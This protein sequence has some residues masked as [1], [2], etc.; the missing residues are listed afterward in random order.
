M[1]HQMILE[2]ALAQ[3]AIDLNCTPED[4]TCPGNKVVLSAPHPH[5]RRY[6]KLPFHCNLVT[7]G[8]GAV[9]S[10][11]PGLEDTVLRY[12]DSCAPGH[13]FDMPDLNRLSDMMSPHGLRVR[14]MAEYFLPASD[15]PSTPSC[16]FETRL[17]QPDDFASLYRPEW[18][19][20]LCEKRK[21]L[22]SLAVGAY[23]HGRLVGLAGAS[24]DCGTMW[25]IG[26]DVLP[27]YRRQGIA[28][29][30]TAR[31][32]A[33]IF[34]R[35]KVPFYCAAWCN[36]PSVRNAIRAGFRPAWSELTLFPDG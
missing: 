6:L 27:E 9:A 36:L 23:D 3:S 32:S 33:E 10:V 19:N 18:S 25:Q 2:T 14:Y 16:P 28:S 12:M 8:T 17:M 11:R 7:Y 4:L 21:E 30:L 34:L 1:T 35:G 24:A 29:A 22:D 5:A 15:Q 31:L 20:A 13:L 26:I